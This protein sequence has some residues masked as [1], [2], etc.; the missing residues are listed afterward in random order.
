MCARVRSESSATITISVDEFQVVTSDGGQYSGRGT[1][2][3][4]SLG[5]NVTSLD[6]NEMLTGYVSFEVRTGRASRRLSAG[7]S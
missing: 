1:P 5:N 2:F 7:A 3:E 6:T 4:P